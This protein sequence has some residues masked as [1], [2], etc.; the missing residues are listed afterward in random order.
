M[1]KPLGSYGLG[2]HH[3]VGS[4][5]VNHGVPREKMEVEG[6]VWNTI[7]GFSSRVEAMLPVMLSEGVNKGRI[8]LPRLVKVCCENPAKAF[9]L[10]PKKGLLR[11]GSDADLVLVDLKKKQKIDKSMLFSTA[12]WSVFE[13]REVTG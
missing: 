1:E 9:G 13:G 5:H 10:Y 8:S 11:V 12:S 2:G 3:C 4:D 6:D 7:S